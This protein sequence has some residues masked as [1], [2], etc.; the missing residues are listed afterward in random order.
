MKLLI[1]MNL[2]PFLTEILNK[3]G[4]ETQLKRGALISIDEARSRVRIL[5][6]I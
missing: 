3:A 6:V 1:D 2:S 5:P 4:Y